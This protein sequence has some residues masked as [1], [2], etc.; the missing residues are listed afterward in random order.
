MNDQEKEAYEEPQVLRE[1]IEDLKARKFRLD[2]G[3]YA[4]HIITDIM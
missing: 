4:V 2:C 1:I 3:H